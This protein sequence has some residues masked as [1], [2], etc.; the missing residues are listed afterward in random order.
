[1]PVTPESEPDGNSPV[2][3]LL[4]WLETLGI[5]AVFLLLGAWN[6]PEDPFY[7]TDNFPWPVLAPLLI[8]LR[9]G[10]FMALV[11]AL[12]V[13]ASLGFTLRA[14][15]QLENFPYVWATGVLGVSLLAGEF[16]DYWNRQQQK[17]EAS[18]RYRE[19]RLEEFTRNF[20]LL[21][22][23]HDRLE[24]QLA[25][26]SNSLREA[27]RRLYHDIGEIGPGGLDRHSAQAMLALLARYGHLQVAAIYPVSQGECGEAAFATVG[28]YR[29]VSR[30][31]PLLLHALAERKMV[32]IQ[33]EYQ[34]KLDTLDTDL[35][36]AIPLIDS[37][38]RFVAICVVEAMPFFNF[39]PKTLRLLAIMA[40]HMGDIITEKSRIATR[41][42]QQWRQLRR[43]LERVGQDAERFSLT[44]SLVSLRLGNEQ[45]PQQISEYVHRMCRGLDVIAEHTTE[46]QRLIVVLM[47]LTDELG[48]AGY[49][50]RMDE[51]L[52]EHLGLARGQLPAPQSLQITGADQ[53]RQWLDQ[54]LAE[55]GVVTDNARESAL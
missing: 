13:I 34:Q 42:P 2:P 52:R 19:S 44:G 15:G 18:N 50:Q 38:D 12:L 53:A 32:S 28:R 4:R 11:S 16:R 1:M 54:R 45:N 3:Q 5:T 24:Q 43:H 41:E 31:D 35:L 6:R 10:F 7:L 8:G 9:Y 22:V 14:N 21:K 37:Q 33:S 55:V 46:Q 20:Y 25:G 36:A 23:S 51:G 47:P 27:L 48:L 49:L 39:E 29:P 40:G 26:S 17:L 30:Q